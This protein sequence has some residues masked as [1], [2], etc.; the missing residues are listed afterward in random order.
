M[1][2]SAKSFYSLI[3]FFQTV[4]VNNECICFSL[5]CWGSSITSSNS[6]CRFHFKFWT[7]QE[8]NLNCLWSTT[9][10][11]QSISHLSSHSQGVMW[12]LHMDETNVNSKQHEEHVFRL[13]LDWETTGTRCLLV[14]HQWAAGRSIKENE[15]NEHVVLGC[16][17]TPTAGGVGGQLVL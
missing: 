13:P 16:L 15:N 11:K 3:C 1:K 6:E 14:C 9:M 8:K 2:T 10:G 5:G 7:K 12:L 17:L 4:W